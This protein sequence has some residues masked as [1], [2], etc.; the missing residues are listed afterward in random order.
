MF[1]RLSLGDLP[2]CKS[3]RG[4]EDLGKL[5]KMEKRKSVELTKCPFSYNL[6]NPR[7]SFYIAERRHR[8]L[9]NRL[10]FIST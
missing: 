1:P 2:G 3:M 7:H 5:V 8:T 6:T 10:V 4:R 9:W